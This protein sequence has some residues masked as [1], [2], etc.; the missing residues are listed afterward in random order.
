MAQPPELLPEVNPASEGDER[1]AAFDVSMLNPPPD[2]TLN[3]R[4]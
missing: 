2:G 1:L 3:G 4:R